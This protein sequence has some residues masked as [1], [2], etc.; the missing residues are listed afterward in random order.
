MWVD[1]RVPNNSLV[2]LLVF[3]PAHLRTQIWLAALVGGPLINGIWQR[4]ELVMIQR[5]SNNV[6]LPRREPHRG[7]H[8][9]RDEVFLIRPAK[10]IQ[11]IKRIGVHKYLHKLDI[12]AY[13]RRGRKYATANHYETSDQRN[14]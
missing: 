5:V 4:E 1:R 8:G 6:L 12:V 9:T 2:L 3:Y 11:F 13:S 14:E 10:G 7:L